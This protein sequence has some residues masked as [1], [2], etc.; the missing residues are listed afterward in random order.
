[1]YS[2]YV[3]EVFLKRPGECTANV[4]GKFSFSELENVQRMC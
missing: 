3:R 2:E 4:V 1:M